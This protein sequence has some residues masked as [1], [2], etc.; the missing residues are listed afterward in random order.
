[1]KKFLKRGKV[2]Q[3]SEGFLNEE[4]ILNIVKNNIHEVVFKF[5]VIIGCSMILN[6]LPFILQID[7]IIL[8]LFSRKCI[9][10]DDFFT[11]DTF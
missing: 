9:E 11:L 4:S 5:A 8:K 1:M 2:F 6:S 3:M 10:R 7:F